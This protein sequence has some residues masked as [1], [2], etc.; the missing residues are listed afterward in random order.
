MLPGQ[1]SDTLK[2][3]RKVQANFSDSVLFSLMRQYTPIGN[4]LPDELNRT[5]S[6]YEY[7]IAADEFEA[8]GL[9][10]FIQSD[11]AVGTDKIPKFNL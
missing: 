3:M 9:E 5:I 1:I 10:G 6:D 4:N 2:I 8:L 11:E 7:V